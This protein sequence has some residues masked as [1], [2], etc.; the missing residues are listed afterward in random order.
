MT[1]LFILALLLSYYWYFYYSYSKNI[2]TSVHSKPSNNPLQPALILDERINSFI[3]ASKNFWSFNLP[4][5]FIVYKGKIVEQTAC[6]N[7][8]NGQSVLAS[9]KELYDILKT[10]TIFQDSLIRPNDLSLIYRSDN[11]FYFKCFNEKIKQIHLCPVGYLYSNKHG[12]CIAIQK[13]LGEPNGTFFSHETDNSKYIECVDEETIER[14]CPD[15][16]IFIHNKCHSVH[17][18]I[19]YCTYNT[20]PFLINPTSQVRCKDKQ[21]FIVQCEPGYQFFHNNGDCESTVCLG[22]PDGFKVALPDEST[23]SFIYKLGYNMCNN[24]KLSSENIYCRSHWDTLQSKDENLSI[25]MANL[26][27]VFDGKKC[28]I[29]TFCENVLPTN[30]DVIVPVHRFTKHLPNWKYSMQFDSV[31]GYQCDYGNQTLDELLKNKN[32]KRKFTEL[33]EGKQIKRF[34]I[35][36]CQDGFIPILGNNTKYYD[37]ENKKVITCQRYEHFNGEKCMINQTFAFRYKDIDVF[38]FDNMNK[39]DGWM[40]TWSYASTDTKSI[41]DSCT[42][43]EP[44]YINNY[45]ICS[46]PDCKHYPFLYHIPDF[47]V[48]LPEKGFKCVLSDNAIKKESVNYNYTFWNQRKSLEE[49]IDEEPCTPGQLISTGNFIWDNTIYAT[50][51]LEQPFVF[52]PSSETDGI[53]QVNNGNRFACKLKDH[54]DNPLFQ[55]YDIE[56]FKPNELEEIET[57]HP[58]TEIILDRTKFILGPNNKK[59]IPS[60]KA[61]NLQSNNPIRIKYKSRITFPPNVIYKNKTYVMDTRSEFSA[62]IT[63]R[64][65]FTYRPINFNKYNP[66]LFLPDY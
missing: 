51:N 15:K 58:K 60:G 27:M 13:C 21:Y 25:D 7:I 66:K 35:D 3:L 26:P 34:K 11:V 53:T 38:Q 37:C 59:P 4:E 28:T 22:K 39:Y 10:E 5:P 61:I 44:V 57:L 23:S 64:Q 2:S 18:L 33:P 19:L 45:N 16:H 46:H 8:P 56:R 17:N 55:S 1:K 52:C 36:T 42:D 12:T 50:C 63:G 41:E 49:N 62:F 29:P 54:Y 6:Q 65:D 20:E 48:L 24:E 32:G 47:S 31:H 40:K 43:T 9:G 14:K 30:P